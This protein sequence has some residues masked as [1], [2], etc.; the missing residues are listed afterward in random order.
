MATDTIL[1]EA[2][3]TAAVRDAM[4]D[5]VTRAKAILSGQRAVPPLPA[6]AE[7]ETFLAR[8][9]AG[10]SPSPTPDAVRMIRERLTLEAVYR[11]TPVACC[12]TADGDL[13]VLAEGDDEI[14]YVL[15]SLNDDEAHRVV[16]LDTLAY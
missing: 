6:P 3:P 5:V 16:V 12:T 13:A 15:A 2:D 14:A 1:E 8:Q 11:G 9:Y 4:T 10:L 7:V